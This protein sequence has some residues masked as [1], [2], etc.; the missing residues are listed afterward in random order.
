MRSA[1]YLQWYDLADNWSNHRI[2]VPQSIG[3]DNA[4]AGE[5]GFCKLLERIAGLLGILYK[6]VA[7]KL[8]AGM[9]RAPGLLLLNMF[10]LGRVHYVMMATYKIEC[11]TERLTGKA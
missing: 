5:Y 10:N 8:N 7:R 11:L 6:Q 1:L 2:E 3:K 4:F 9:F